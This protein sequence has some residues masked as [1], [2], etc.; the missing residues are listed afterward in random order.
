[1]ADDF[2]QAAQHQQ[3]LGKSFVNK[4]NEIV[5]RIGG[6]QWTRT[7]LVQIIGVGNF[8]AAG[9]LSTVLRKK[10]ISTVEGLY[11]IDPRDF[12]LIPHLGETTVF[13]AMAIL[14]AEGFDVTH[15]TSQVIGARKRILTFRTLKVQQ[16]KGKR[17]RK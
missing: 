7:Q 9:K 3:F 2:I 4:Q 10:N 11:R 13:V 5:L 1:M 15:W 8:A 17:G 12:A 14:K 6:R 16:Q